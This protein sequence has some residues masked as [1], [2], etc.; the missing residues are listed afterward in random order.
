MPFFFECFSCIDRLA[1]YTSQPSSGLMPP[2][3]ALHFWYSSTAPNMLPWSVRA[4][5]LCPSSSQALHHIADPVRA[6][7]QAVLGM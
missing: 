3:V 7:E 2:F 4:R 6:V 5:A 1:M